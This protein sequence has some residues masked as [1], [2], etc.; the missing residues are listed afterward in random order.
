MEVLCTIWHKYAANETSKQ[1]SVWMQLG[2]SINGVDFFIYF[3][4]S[5]EKESEELQIQCTDTDVTE[6]FGSTGSV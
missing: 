6:H 3:F 2:K 4:F 1:V 5:R